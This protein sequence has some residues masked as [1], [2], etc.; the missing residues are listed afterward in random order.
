MC[1][2]GGEGGT[3]GKISVKFAIC[4]I[5]VKKIVEIIKYVTFKKCLATPIDCS[6]LALLRLAFLSLFTI[7]IFLIGIAVWISGEKVFLVFE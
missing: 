1:E 6:T 4:T 5:F 3:V 7:F 2:G